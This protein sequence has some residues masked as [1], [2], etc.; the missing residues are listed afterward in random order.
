MMQNKFLIFKI[1]C[2]NFAEKNAQI[3]GGKISDR[4]RGNQDEKTNGGTEIGEVGFGTQNVHGGGT[5]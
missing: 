2:R 4:E 5:R 1:S 3:F